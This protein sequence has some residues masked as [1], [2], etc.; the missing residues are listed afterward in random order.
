MKNIK[1]KEYSVKL[2]LILLVFAIMIFSN[3]A[4]VLIYAIILKLGVINPQR[5]NPLIV[6][7]V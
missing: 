1:N 2:Q 3:I 6:G 7:T 5:F 4:I